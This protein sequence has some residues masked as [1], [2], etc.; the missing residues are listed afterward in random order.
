MVTHIP[1]RRTHR[2]RRKLPQRRSLLNASFW[3]QAHLFR[4]HR[5]SSTSNLRNWRLRPGLSHL[6][7]RLL[8]FTRRRFYLLPSIRYH[9]FG[10]RTKRPYR[11]LERN[12]RRQRMLRHPHP[13]PLVSLAIILLI[14]SDI[15][16]SHPH[17][18]LFLA[19]LTKI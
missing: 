10:W 7:S 8:L 13:S 4:Y 12:Y 15:I 6:L 16:P 5:R 11:P 19:L 9:C 17:G 1:Q 14:L 3:R 18:W 2:L